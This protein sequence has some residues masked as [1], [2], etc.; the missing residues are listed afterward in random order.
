MERDMVWWTKVEDKMDRR[1][2]QNMRPRYVV[3]IRPLGII[4]RLKRILISRTG[5]DG[6]AITQEGIKVK[7]VKNVLRKSTHT[8][9]SL[10]VGKPKA[11]K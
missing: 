4:G 6:M 8:G 2:G 7:K 10:N 3:R 1:P 9:T 11:R 5:N